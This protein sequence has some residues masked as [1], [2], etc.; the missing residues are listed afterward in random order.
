MSLIT[1]SKE[2]YLH[3][4]NVIKEH[5]KDIKKI[6]LVLK[7]NAY[8]HGLLE[9]AT[10]A[11]EFGIES[12]VVKNRIEARALRGRFKRILILYDIPLESE[13][14]DFYYAIN[15]LES[16][17]SLKKGAKVELK[18]DSGMHRNGIERENLREAFELISKK[19]LDL[20]AVFTHYRAGDDLGSE[21]FWQQKIFE[22]IKEES[23]KLSLEYGFR[24]ISYHSL[25][26]SSFFRQNSIEDDFVRV[27]IAS[28]GYLESDDV[29]KKVDLRAVLKLYAHK[30]ST[31]ALKRGDRVGYSGCSEIE[32]DCEISSYDIGYGDG[33]FRIR[34][35]MEYTLPS[36]A[37]LL[38]RVSMDSFSAIS[39]ECEILLFDDAKKVAKL[40]DTISY[41]ILV[42][43]SPYL[44]RVVV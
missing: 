25:S 27:G 15:S 11:H 29:F 9:C 23:Y 24:D 37:K 1:I 44:R 39:K 34:E 38:P 40:F 28:Y 2:S 12:V 30:I 35:G 19:E 17:S 36:G 22:E 41:D 31:R 32:S 43:L 10:L 16:I 18:V 21:L 8:G 6:Y 13:D 14:L 7:D 4:L 3:N 20:R 5:A 26:S 42:K 33:F